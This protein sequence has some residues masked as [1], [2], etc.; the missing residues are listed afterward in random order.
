MNPFSGFLQPQNNRPLEG[1]A[2]AQDLLRTIQGNKELAHRKLENEQQNTRSNARLAMEQAYQSRK[3]SQEDQKQVESLLAEY[4]DAEDQGDPVRLSRAAQMLQRFGMNV[5][6]GPAA[7]PDLRAFTGERVLPNV[8]KAPTPEALQ[9]L[10]G[11]PQNPIDS[12]VQQELK[13]RAALQA[14]NAAPEQDLSQED[15]ESQLIA[16]SGNLPERMEKGGET[17][18]EMKALL[19]QAPEEQPVDMGDVDSPE[20]KRAAAEEQGVIDLDA[21]DPRP[22]QIGG[23]QPQAPPTPPRRLS[24]QLLPTVISKDGKKLYE[25]TGPSGRW[26]PMVKGVFEPFAQHGNADIASAAQRAQQMAGKLI[27]VDGVAP[28]DAIKLGMDYL[29]GEANRVIGLERTKLGSRPRGVGGVGSGLLGKT[30]DIAESA[31]IYDDNARAQAEKL[32]QEDVQYESIEGAINSNDP[33]LQRDAVN[34]LLKIRS[35]TAVTAAED[36]RISQINGLLAQVQDR[37]GRWSGGAMTPEMRRTIQQI[38]ALKRQVSQAKIKRIY[39]HQARIYEAQNEGKIKDPEILRKR[40]TVIRQGAS[41][42][43]GEPTEEDLY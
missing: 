16:G 4:Q 6:E 41:V 32:Q 1:L 9:A 26:A 42:A 39:E 43:T 21:E 22:L 17:T 34:Q 35:G 5:G 10:T 27:E 18:P 36:A 8:P 28:K 19:P 29:N 14:K 25:S 38:V 20:F 24:T 30:Q 2:T 15:F 33:A 3:F 13:S 23:D 7:K 12:A 31:Q 40:A 11:Q 37:L